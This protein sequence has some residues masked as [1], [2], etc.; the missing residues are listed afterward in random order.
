MYL[1]NVTDYDNITDSDN[2]S[3]CICTNNDNNDTNSEIVLPVIT[4]ITCA[5]SLI[6]S[7]SLMVYTLIKPLFNR[8]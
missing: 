4:I 5:M 2:M 1:T 3:L 7:K 8:K 6:C